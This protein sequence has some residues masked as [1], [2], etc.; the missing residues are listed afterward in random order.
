MSSEAV[1]KGL[2]SGTVGALG[3]DVYEREAGSEG[4]KGEMLGK[5]S[6]NPEITQK[7]IYRNGSII[8]L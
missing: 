2:R 5:S 3:L 7:C 1:W 8:F 6:G 4:D